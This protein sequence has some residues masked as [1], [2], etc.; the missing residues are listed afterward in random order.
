MC[1]LL[2]SE[3][4]CIRQTTEREAES[5]D[6]SPLPSLFPYYCIR[7]TSPTHHGHTNL[8]NRCPR[9]NRIHGCLYR[10]SSST[11]PTNRS[12]MGYCRTIRAKTVNPFISNYQAS[13]SRPGGSSDR[14]L[15]IGLP[16]AGR[17]NKKD[18]STD[19]RHWTVPHLL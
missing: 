17:I 8:R 16:G 14:N 1:S 6:I 4:Y 11:I 12:Q 7:L 13:K 10:G 18:Q 19:Q 5:Y 15:H 3:F 9:R 2:I